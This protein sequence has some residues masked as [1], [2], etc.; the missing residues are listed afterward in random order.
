M[1]KETETE[2]E[3]NEKRIQTATLMV[4]LFNKVKGE[5]RRKMGEGEDRRF[6]R[7]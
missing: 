4:I 7:V 5:R 6:P 2:I 1:A 3:I